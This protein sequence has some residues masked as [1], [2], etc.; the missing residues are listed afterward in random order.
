MGSWSGS[1]PLNGSRIFKGFSWGSRTYSLTYS[2]SNGFTSQVVAVEIAY[3]IDPPL[4]STMMSMTNGSLA[5]TLVTQRSTYAIAG[6][7][8]AVRVNGDPDNTKNGLFY[9]YSDHLGSTSAI[10]KDGSTEVEQSRY[11]PF[12]GWRGDKPDNLPGNRGYTGHVMNNLGG[13]ADDLGLIYMN[14]R[15]YV[16]N[17]NRFLTPDTIVPDP[18][19]PQSFNR[20]SYVYNNP[21]THT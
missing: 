21:M 10:Q 11:L 18:T 20:Y 14:A 17:T 9:M 3:I 7:T 4:D 13:G 8:I 19:N 5:G 1:Q 15:Y 12:G 2:N 6:Q 16:P